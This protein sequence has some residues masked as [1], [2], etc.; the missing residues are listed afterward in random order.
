MP[1]VLVLVLVLVFDLISWRHFD[2]HHGNLDKTLPDLVFAKS[3]NNLGLASIVATAR[4]PL[5]EAALPS[6]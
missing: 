5:T 4:L 2:V 6:E 1:L 3:C